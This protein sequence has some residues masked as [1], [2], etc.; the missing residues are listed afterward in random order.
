[1]RGLLA[2]FLGIAVSGVWAQS[3]VWEI[4][5][6]A[7]I[8]Y[9][10]GSLEAMKEADL[11]LPPEFDLAYTRSEKM[12]FEADT[13]EFSRP[14]NQGQLMRKMLLVEESLFDRIEQ[15]T[16]VSLV[17]LVRSRGLSE[18]MFEGMRTPLV[19]ANLR[20]MEYQRLGLLT[21]LSTS[22]I[23]DGRARR[24]RKT[25]VGLE[26][27]QARMNAMLAGAEGVED[28]YLLRTIHD[29]ARLKDSHPAMLR[30]WRKGN[31]AALTRLSLLGYLKDYP[32]VYE[33]NFTGR[34][35]RWMPSLEF[36]LRD[37]P[38]EFVLIDLPYLL[39]P[40]GLLARF[41]AIDGVEVVPLILP[42]EE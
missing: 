10:G 12:I 16:F 33:K 41:R 11:P 37:S 8:M 9:L 28:S 18:Q 4:R 2:F 30:G 34:I 26:T 22:G 31:E 17:G 25:I 21:T 40:D 13:V 3:A 36:Y 19:A 7:R 20:A 6:G 14:E 29:V 15:E 42:E 23:L 38:R 27:P 5:K 24:D 39:G 32:E 1:M 35:D